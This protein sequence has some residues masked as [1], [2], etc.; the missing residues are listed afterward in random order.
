[1]PFLALDL[2]ELSLVGVT[3]K[4]PP[5][6]TQYDILYGSGGHTTGIHVGK[7][8]QTFAISN[9][10][11]QKQERGI[12]LARSGRAADHEE[13]CRSPPRSLSVT[14]KAMRNYLALQEKKMTV[15]GRGTNYDPS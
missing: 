1:M 9:M 10:K 4:Q 3:N 2:N 14:T 11:N 6:H 12:N 8:I 7:W 5:R 15:Y 13:S